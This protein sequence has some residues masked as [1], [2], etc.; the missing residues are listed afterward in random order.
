MAWILPCPL[1]LGSDVDHITLCFHN[2]SHSRGIL[3]SP[4]LLLSDK[5][6]EGMAAPGKSS[7]WK[8]RLAG[9][10]PEITL[11]CDR[12]HG[13]ISDSNV[14]FRSMSRPEPEPEP[15]EIVHVDGEETAA[16]PSSGLSIQREL[17]GLVSTLVNCRITIFV[18]NKRFLW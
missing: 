18:Y 9:L 12:D 13:A 7:Q 2:P 4:P 11:L 16:G 17:T 6:G 14:R 15:G 3:R 1:G 5:L 8:L 10:P